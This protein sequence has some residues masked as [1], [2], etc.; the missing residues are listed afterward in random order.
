M[1]MVRE[2]CNT[3]SLPESQHHLEAE[4]ERNELDVEMGSNL[5]TIW[6]FSSSGSCLVSSFDV[7]TNYSI[8]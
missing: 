4:K 1:S 7:L 2:S 5:G 6:D 8:L 3:T